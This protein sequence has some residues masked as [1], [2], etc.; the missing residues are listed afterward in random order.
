MNSKRLLPE[1]RLLMILQIVCAG[2][3]IAALPSGMIHPGWLATFIIPSVL[4]LA[5][6][7][8]GLRRYV[9]AWLR[10]TLALALQGIA[11]SL[12]YEFLVDHPLTERSSL[13]CSLLPA[14]SFFTL[15]RQ[16]SDTSLSLFLSFCFLLIGIVLNDDIADWTLLVFLVS[17]P[18]AM[19]IEASN[20]SLLQRHTARGRS[21][22]FSTR[23]LRRA[24]VVIALTL[25]A[26]FTYFLV[27]LVPSPGEERRNRRN[28]HSSNSHQNRRVGL[29]HRFD[30]SG[31]QGSP[32]N[33]SADEVLHVEAPYGAT[34]P[35]DLYLRMAFFDHP[36][37]Q[38]W[39]TWPI[40][41][42]TRPLNGRWFYC[43]EAFRNSSS[44]RRRLV[45]RRITPSSEGELYLPPGTIGIRGIDRLEFDNIAG[46]YRSVGAEENSYNVTYQQLRKHA[47]Y[48][49]ALRNTERLNRL[50]D[51]P[52]SL[53]TEKLEALAREFGGPNPESLKPMVLAKRI[54]RR[55]RALCKYELRDPRGPYKDPIHNFLFGSNTGYC[56]HFATS[57]AIMLRMHHVP[58]RIGVGFQ[59]G[60]SKG[61]RSRTFGSR[62]AHAWVEIPLVNFDW[63]VI[64]PTPTADRARRGWPDP[65]ANS[66]AGVEGDASGVLSDSCFVSGLSP[67]LD[68]PLSILRNPL[69]HPGPF[70]FLLGVFAFVTLSLV[71]LVKRGATGDKD[72]KG[73]NKPT[74][75]TVKARQLLENIL[76]GLSKHGHSKNHRA[77]LEQFT[78]ILEFRD[79]EVDL[80]VLRLAFD[81]YQQIRF[82]QKELAGERH[83]NLIAGLDTVRALPS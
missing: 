5:L 3:A 23:V 37:L 14:L 49:R 70:L 30:L 68:D 7:A 36:G 47:N 61:D 28:N 42:I 57:L 26:L 60:K 38:E 74:P 12:A 75:D 56:M 6:G 20:R 66:P 78:T 1:S 2:S 58:C 45:I 72:A 10:V 50:D 19:Q 13:A 11:A 71:A 17:C 69:R 77:T 43:K 8:H 29:S 41:S 31:G 53:R 63:V 21:M 40:N 64:D 65:S 52:R 76:A 59:G 44:P 83:D 80:P 46:H 33:I 22:T 62:H 15:R 82:G 34:V 35:N 55:L 18:W 79:V 73:G 48:S 54:S 51:L 39:K 32:L 67:L 25:V 27:G 4:F 81:S 24:Q 16:P 9:P